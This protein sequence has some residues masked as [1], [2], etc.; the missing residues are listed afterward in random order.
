MDVRHANMLC[1]IKSMDQSS[2][3]VSD[4]CSAE[5]DWQGTLGLIQ[6]MNLL[7]LALELSQKGS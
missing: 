4:F 3:R 2:C 5:N 6:H 1:K 7:V